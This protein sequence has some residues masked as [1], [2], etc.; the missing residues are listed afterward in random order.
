[1]IETFDPIYIATLIQNTI[2]QIIEL[3]K[4]SK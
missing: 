3:K 4:W 1:M 2:F